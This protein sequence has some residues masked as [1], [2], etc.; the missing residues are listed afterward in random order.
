MKM[1]FPEETAKFVI[2]ERL[3]ILRKGKHNIRIIEIV[4]DEEWA[5][6]KKIYPGQPFTGVIRQVKEQLRADAEE[7]GEDLTPNKI[8][9]ELSRRKR[10]ETIKV[11]N[12]PDIE[13]PRRVQNWLMGVKLKNNDSSKR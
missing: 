2:D 6:S 3:L 11:A 7:K 9:K 4:S 8:V 1:W 13:L 5:K 10:E 12:N